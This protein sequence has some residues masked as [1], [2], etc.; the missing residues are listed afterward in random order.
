MDSPQMIPNTYV[1]VPDQLKKD[2]IE[3]AAVIQ[4]RHGRDEPKG[5]RSV[6]FARRAF[7]S[8]KP[9]SALAVVLNT[10]YTLATKSDY[11]GHLQVLA[12]GP[13]ASTET[14]AL[15]GLLHEIQQIIQRSVDKNKDPHVD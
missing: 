10:N 11:K 15:Q 5:P 8:E 9:L 7:P 6:L 1:S 2:I 14:A 3:H 4:Y 12:E 13:K